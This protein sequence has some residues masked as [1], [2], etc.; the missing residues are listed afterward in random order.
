MSEKKFKAIF[1]NISDCIVDF[2]DKIFKLLIQIKYANK[3]I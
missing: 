1:N 2:F 3:I